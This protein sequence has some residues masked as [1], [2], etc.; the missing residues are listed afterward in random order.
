MKKLSI[1]LFGIVS[2]V[3]GLSGLTA[4]MLFMGGWAFLPLHINSNV[5]DVNTTQ[6]VLLNVFMLVLFGLHHSIAARDRFK[7][8]LAQFV[9]EKIER[10]LFVFISGGFMFAICMFWQPLS[11]VVW[12]TDNASL[13]FALKTIHV[14]GWLVLV[15]ATVEIDHF[16]L[17]GLKQSLS[18]DG[19]DSMAL[20]E[21]YLYSIVR[22][23]IQTGILMGIWFTPYMSMTQF[24]LAVCLTCYI[25]IGLHYEERS[26]EAHFG[27]LYRDY[28][29]RVPAVIPFW[30]TR[31]IQKLTRNRFTKAST[32]K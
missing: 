11:G 10:S 3:I 8:K 5:T 26:L 4:F 15:A 32:P 30:P 19:E 20:K 24:M 1:S 28:K 18:I 9:S 17:M 21:N 13:A 7:K 14:I 6:A 29:K 16:H 23:P 25:F 2:Y 27:D 31:H 22:H 12:M